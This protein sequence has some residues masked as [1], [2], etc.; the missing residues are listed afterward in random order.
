LAFNNTKVNSNLVKEETI[1]FLAFKI[2][3]MG[4]KLFVEAEWHQPISRA[5]QRISDAIL[6]VGNSSQKYLALNHTLLHSDT[7]RVAKTAGLHL[8]VNKAMHFRWQQLKEM[9]A[10]AMSTA[11]QRGQ[12]STDNATFGETIITAVALDVTSEEAGPSV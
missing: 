5:Q 10:V 8:D 3:R 4:I 1:N 7:R 11:K 12:V 9:L 2:N 6:S